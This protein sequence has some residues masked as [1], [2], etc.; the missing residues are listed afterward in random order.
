MRDSLSSAL[1]RAEDEAQSRPGK[2][3]HRSTFGLRRISL[4]GTHSIDYLGG[5]YDGGY[6]VVLEDCAVEAELADW[7]AH[8]T[9]KGLTYQVSYVEW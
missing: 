7:L 1:K 2:V 5:A 9:Q 4:R 6:Q 3:K 8:L